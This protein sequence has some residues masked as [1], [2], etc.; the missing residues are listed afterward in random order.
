MGPL[1]EISGEAGR[2]PD[3]RG[4]TVASMGPLI[5]I[6]GEQGEIVLDGLNGDTLQ[7]GR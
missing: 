4:G 2:G 7:W 3:G 5:E 6:S 1:I